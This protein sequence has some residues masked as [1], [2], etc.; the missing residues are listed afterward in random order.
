MEIGKHKPTLID[1]QE[2]NVSKS[3]QQN[4]EG[5]IAPT[6]LPPFPNQAE[7][8]RLRKRETASTITI[9]TIRRETGIRFSYCNQIKCLQVFKLFKATTSQ[10]WWRKKREGKNT[11]LR[12]DTHSLGRCWQVTRTLNQ[13]HQEVSKSL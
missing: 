3:T 2:S 5:K 8:I 4:R 12:F 7:L 13:E 11:S 1:Q 10:G 6:S 9:Q